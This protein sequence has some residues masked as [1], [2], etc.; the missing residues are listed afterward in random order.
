MH[1]PSLCKVSDCLK[2]S[3][4]V[5]FHISYET[6]FLSNVNIVTRHWESAMY[7]YTGVSESNLFLIQYKRPRRP[8]IWKLESLQ[9]PQIGDFTLGDIRYKFL[10]HFYYLF[11]KKIWGWR[12]L[13]RK[14]WVQCSGSWS[15][16]ENYLH[17]SCPQK[18]TSPQNESEEEC[19]YK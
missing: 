7:V 19:G 1:I 5:C 8:R 12:K 2:Y 3:T 10:S 16:P 14:N 15:I 17:V 13:P 11:Q 18:K 9:R 6:V 4:G